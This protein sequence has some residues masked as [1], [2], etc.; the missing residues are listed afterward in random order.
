M[1]VILYGFGIAGVGWFGFV[2]LWWVCCEVWFVGI[3]FG[4]VG[5]L[6]SF[7][8]DGCGLGFRWVCDCGCQVIGWFEL[9]LGCV[10]LW[11]VL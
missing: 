6:F 10:C 8:F 1:L 2:D 5:L 11:F 3:G 4:W 7:G 9:R